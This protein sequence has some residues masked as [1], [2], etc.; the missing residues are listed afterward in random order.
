M[1][2]H[3]RTN[4]DSSAGFLYSDQPDSIAFGES[5]IP[6]PDLTDRIRG[7]AALYVERGLRL[8]SFWTLVGF[9][10]G[11]DFGHSE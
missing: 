4:L 5:S 1:R 3:F 11:C 6:L 7:Q 2:P 8:D 9:G 10:Y